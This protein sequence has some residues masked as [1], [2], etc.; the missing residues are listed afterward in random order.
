MVGA[1]SYTLHEDDDPSF[2]SPLSFY[3]GSNSHY[4][5]S[6]QAPGTWYYR[7]RA[8]NEISNS[9]W[10]N[11]E[12][13]E[14]YVPP[15]EIAISG[16]VTGTIRANYTFTAG[17]NPV[18]TPTPITYDWQ[19]SPSASQQIIT[20]TSGVSDTAVISWTTAGSHAITVTA[21]NA[22]GSVSGTHA[23]LNNL[24][25]YTLDVTTVG[26]G[27]VTLNPT[28]GT[29]TEGTVVT[30]TANPD[31]GWHFSGW[32][33][34]LSTMTNPVT[35]TMD[36]N[37]IVTATFAQDEYT[38]ALNT[39]DSGTVISDPAQSTYHYGDVVT[40]TAIPTTGWHFAGWSGDLNSADNPETLTMD[41]HKIVTATFS[42][43]PPTTYTLDVNVEGQ[44]TT[45]P[46]VGSHSYISGT[47][48][49]VEAMPDDGWHFAGWNGNLSGTT[50]PV[51]LTM[52]AD[53]II[54]ATFAQ[55]EYTLALHKV[56]SG[57]VI[58]EPVQSIYHYGDVVT[59]TAIPTTGWHFAGWS[60]NLSGATNPITLTMDGNQIVT[61]TFAQ[62]EYTLALNTVDSG[63][64]ISDPA[65]STYHYGDVVTL[66]A[67]PTT[68]WHF[69]G[70]SG[71]L[72]S[73]DNPETLTM[74]GHKIV[75]AT[76]SLTPPTTYTLDVNVEGQGTTMPT[77]GSHS[78]ISG[79]DVTV[80]AM[81][82][83]GWHFAGWN[84]NLSG[85]TNPVTL[86]MDA[87]KIITATF[88]QDEYTLALHKV[89]SG[90]VISEPVQSIYHYGD[91]VTLTAIPTTGWHFAGWGGNLSDTTNPI[92]LTMDGNQIITA[93]FAQDEYTLALHKVGSGTVI[94]EPMQST[95]HYGDVVT[96]TAIPTTGW[97]FVSWSGSL[98]DT[99]NPVT[100]TMDGNQI[101]TATFAQDEYTLALHTVGSGTMISE[102]VQSSYHYGD[103]VTLTAIPTTGDRKSVV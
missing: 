35:L 98:S 100:L 14:V 82:D 54:T 24:P 80:E 101:I 68:G 11:V 12:S 37:Q 93:T 16:P 97:H 34:D 44:G 8:S 79:T 92:T 65:Q 13:T 72:N 3:I 19:I 25:T 59:L 99:T 1:T 21:S 6:G 22:A 81:P 84:G 38:L 78:Y 40:L 23:I 60:G 64:V 49:T 33:G 58:S 90:T 28:G 86:T 26:Q 51:T 67:I 7:V 4:T 5:I 30:I 103:V 32:S 88:A 87:D 95:Y 63:T 9:S 52:D 36:G 20:Y 45:M 15:S 17:V 70:W 39:V 29:Y 77:V 89:G 61:A 10:S 66:T 47:D 41:G 75:T 2:A 74:D 27:S 43:T 53:K 48:V 96:L 85:T 69:A 50:N 56:G 102:P 91:V 46:T 57:T 62:D 76:F 42:L 73:A 18:T 55:D 83:D 94:S 71:D 31:T